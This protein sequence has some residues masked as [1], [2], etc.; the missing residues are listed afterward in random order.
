MAAQ[1]ASCL[2]T[3]HNM[4][5]LP[6]AR[7]HCVQGRPSC[8][9]HVSL[10]DHVEILGTSSGQALNLWRA[11]K[12]RTIRM[13]AALPKRPSA[14]QKIC[15]QNCVNQTSVLEAYGGD[16]TESSSGN[17]KPKHHADPFTS[18]R[19]SKRMGFSVASPPVRTVPVR[20]VVPPRPDTDQL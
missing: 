6:Q 18:K 15:Q 5:P 13:I 2:A 3:P 11:T 4:S 12:S 10:G 1:P 9:H 20:P 14:T 8:A 16:E 19:A 17:R 7:A